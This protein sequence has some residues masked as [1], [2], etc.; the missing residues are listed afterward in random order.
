MNLAE[1]KTKQQ[2]TRYFPNFTPP[3]VSR[4]RT[5]AQSYASILC[6][7]QNTG[8]GGIKSAPLPIVYGF[9]QE[10]NFS[11]KPHPTAL[12]GHG[13]GMKIRLGGYWGL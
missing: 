1:R 7:H 3:L 4:Q 10:Q 2:K 12:P 6:Q 13:A 9:K 5:E 11:I 8:A